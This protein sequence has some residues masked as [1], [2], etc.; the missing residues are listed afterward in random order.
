MRSSPKIEIYLTYEC[1]EA[2][3]PTFTSSCSNWAQSK[4]HKPSSRSSIKSHTSTSSLMIFAKF[5]SFLQP[6]YNHKGKS[7]FLSLS[8]I[9]LNLMTSI[10][11]HIETIYTQIKWSQQKSPT[12]LKSFSKMTKSSST[13]PSA[14]SAPIIATHSLN[15]L[16]IANSGRTDASERIIT[17]LLLSSADTCSIGSVSKI[18]LTWHAPCAGTTSAPKSP[19]S[20]RPPAARNPTPKSTPTPPK[21]NCSCA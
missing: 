6:P 20:V 10:T 14:L 7:T 12:H 15:A 3:S 13:V 11:I 2:Q 8:T 5:L 4:Q 19:A 1:S 16:I 17:W 21:S 18:A 9:Q